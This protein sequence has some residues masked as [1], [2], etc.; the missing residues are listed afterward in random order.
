MKTDT[1]IKQDGFNALKEKFGINTLKIK[2][3][4]I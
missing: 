3:K 1:V 2:V 4:K